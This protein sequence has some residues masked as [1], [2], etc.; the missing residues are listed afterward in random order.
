LL[1]R[2]NSALGLAPHLHSLDHVLGPKV[3]ERSAEA[4]DERVV[5]HGDL[6]A[7]RTALPHAHEP[8]RVDPERRADK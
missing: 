5:V 2:F 8:H 4:V 1:Q 7:C 3:R 6:E